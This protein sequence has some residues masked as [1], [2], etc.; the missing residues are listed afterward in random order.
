MPWYQ[1]G[2]IICCI[3]PGGRANQ[4]TQVI[5]AS[6]YVELAWA[7]IVILHERTFS[8][9]ET[10]CDF[11]LLSQRAFRKKTQGIRRIL[12]IPWNQNVIQIDQ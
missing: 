8:P 7:E 12:R 1:D 4:L 5:V 10:G 2:V 3:R 11:S 6:L 9:L